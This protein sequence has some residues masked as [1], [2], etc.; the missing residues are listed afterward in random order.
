MKTYLSRIFKT[1]DALRAWYAA[2]QADNKSGYL[3][4]FEP[5]ESC[6]KTRAALVAAVDGV[7]DFH[8]CGL[9]SGWNPTLEAMLADFAKAGQIQ[10]DIH[11]A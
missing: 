9:A 7:A 4:G 6:G 11:E 10:I 1:A 2:W 8:F 3:S 5:P